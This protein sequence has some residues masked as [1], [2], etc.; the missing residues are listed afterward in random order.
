VRD[1]CSAQ[2][3]GQT[4]GRA[5]DGPKSLGAAC[6]ALP[7]VSARASEPLLANAAP[8]APLL[9]LKEKDILC[10]VALEHFPSCG[11]RKL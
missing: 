9:S 2:A 1:V 10:P 8:N 11:L 6:E 5:P 7:V 3:D 4:D